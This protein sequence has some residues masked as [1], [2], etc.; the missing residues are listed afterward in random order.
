MSSSRN[1][2][3]K[4][5]ATLN[6]SALNCSNLRSNP[7]PL[8][9]PRDSP[10]IGNVETLCPCMQRKQ[11]KPRGDRRVNRLSRCQCPSRGLNGQLVL[12]R[13]RIHAG[14]RSRSAEKFLIRALTITRPCNNSLRRARV[15]GP[16]RRARCTSP[17]G[18][19]DPRTDNFN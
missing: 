18:P 9:S 15:R 5:A 17:E 8:R 7:L 14:S 3:S 4:Q 1:V 12:N 2:P 13:R 6:Y 16:D 10:R 11:E 19:V